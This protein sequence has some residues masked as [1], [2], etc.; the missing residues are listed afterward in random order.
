VN[1]PVSAG[2]I[3][4]GLAGSP[5]T[6]PLP[7]TAPGTRVKIDPATRAVVDDL[8]VRLK[9]VCAAWRTSWPT[10]AECDASKR[11]WIAEFMVAGIRDASQISY[12]VRM[13][14]AQGGPGY[15]PPPGAFVRW[16]F[17]PEALGLP[18][19]ERAYNLALR[20]THPSQ[21]GHCKWP[22]A[23]VYHASV[24]AG[25]YSLQR[26]DRT[27]GLKRFEE[28]YLEQCRKI[29]RGEEL[30]PVPVA[31]LP[32]RAGARTP[33]VGRAALAELRKKVGGGRG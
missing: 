16:C 21:V 8:F 3:A 2:D 14:R 5:K 11:E 17:A 6:V 30:P 18:D 7:A 28:N 26:L 27:L 20:N 25:W 13:A 19:V 29:G 24:A 32:E 33:E 15:V 31:A 12:G 9:A 23:A 22:H 4:K 1:A 10:D